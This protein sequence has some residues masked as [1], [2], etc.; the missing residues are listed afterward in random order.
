MPIDL[1]QFQMNPEEAALLRELVQS[2]KPKRI[3]EFGSGLTTCFWAENSDA[4]ITTWDNYPEWITELREVFAKAPWLPR[5]DWR[6]YTVTPEGPRSVEKD[7]VPWEGDPF[8]FLFLDG[9]RS[10]HAP[11]FGRSGTFRFATRHAAAGALIVW[12][13]AQRPH[14]KEMARK[15]L[16]HCARHRRGSVG[17][18][19]WEA[20]KSVGSLSKFV[21]KLNPLT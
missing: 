19:R 16:A 15:Y 10:A 17:W 21:R 6:L 8:D 1:N 14:E 13:D 18:C 11:N 4:Q 20:P 12:H 3:A 5:V 7:A 9:P 2:A